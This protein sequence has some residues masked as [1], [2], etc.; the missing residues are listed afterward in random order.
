MQFSELYVQ[1]IPCAC[2]SVCFLSSK[3]SH[4]YWACGRLVFAVLFLYRSIAICQSFTLN[5]WWWWREVSLQETFGNY[6]PNHDPRFHFIEPRYGFSRFTLSR[7][8]KDWHCWSTFFFSNYGSQYTC[9]ICLLYLEIRTYCAV[10]FSLYFISVSLYIVTYFL[11][12]HLVRIQEQYWVDVQ[13]MT[14]AKL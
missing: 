1:H 12:S 2:I 6:N 13:E 9:L 11:L 3:S 8:A 14:A 7:Q 5:N 10:S 4:H